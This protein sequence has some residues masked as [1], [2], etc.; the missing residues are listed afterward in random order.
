LPDWAPIK[1]S[2]CKCDYSYQGLRADMSRGI[3]F[4]AVGW[5]SVLLSWYLMQKFGRRVLFGAGLS[6]LTI[7]MFLVGILDCVP[8]QGAIWAKSTM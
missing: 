2:T 3:G 1:L 6:L 5:I 4:M 8:S 7:I